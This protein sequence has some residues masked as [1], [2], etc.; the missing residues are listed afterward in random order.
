MASEAD[1]RPGGNMESEV[2]YYDPAG[3][4]RTALSSGPERE[5]VKVKYRTLAFKLE[6]GSIAVFPAPHQYFFARDFTTNMG[7]LWHRSWRGGSRR[8]ASCR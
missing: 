7:Y 1:R 2:A 4:F 6:H 5:P 3:R 8:R